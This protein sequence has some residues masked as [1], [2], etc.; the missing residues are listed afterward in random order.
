MLK[1]EKAYRAAL[2]EARL[3]GIVAGYMSEADP[4]QS[5]L[6][7]PSSSAISDRKNPVPPSK[8]KGKR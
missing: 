6:T 1:A 8:M 4:V 3:S 5:P 7:A 2:A